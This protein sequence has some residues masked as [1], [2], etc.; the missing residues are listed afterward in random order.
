MKKSIFLFCFLLNISVSA[1]FWSEL[2]G[3]LSN[4]NFDTFSN[5]A[6][7]YD[8]EL[9]NGEVVYI[10]AKDR[11]EQWNG[12]SWSYV[13]SNGIPTTYTAGL[14]LVFCLATDNLGNLY[15]AGR[16][17]NS[18]GNKFV[19]KWDGTA[20][21][22]LGGQNAL[23]AN[24]DI[25]AIYIDAN[26]NVFV[27]GKFKN[28]QG[29]VYVAKYD[30]VSWSSLGG[31]GLTDN[32]LDY[33]NGLAGSANGTIYCAGSFANNSSNQYLAACNQQGWFELGGNNGLAGNYASSNWGGEMNSVVV[34]A[35]NNVYV[36]GNFTNDSGNRFVAKYNGSAWSELGGANALASLG[37]FNGGVSYISD[38]YSVN[39][40]I[41]VTGN[42]TSSGP[43]RFVAR[44]YNNQWTELGADGS[45]G[46]TSWIN[47]IAANNSQI[48]VAGNFGYSLFNGNVTARYVATADYNVVLTSGCMDPAACNFDPDAVISGDC[49]F[50]G[51]ACDD[52]NV[53]TM[54]DVYNDLCECTGMLIIPGCMDPLACNYDVLANMDDGGCL[55]EG[56]PCDDGD[57]NTMNDV[58]SANC[59]CIGTMIIS[60]CT[61]ASACN[62]NVDAN[63]D[64]GSCW[65]VGDVCDD[66]NSNTINDAVNANCE[67]QG[68][69]ISEVE[70]GVIATIKIFPIPANHQ[71]T[72]QW[73]S[74]PAESIQVFDMQGARVT[75]IAPSA[76]QV[77]NTSNWSNG[78][79][80]LLSS[81]GTLRSKIEIR[82]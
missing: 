82:H 71:L 63:T 6:M 5:N 35:Q 42:Y 11:V 81:N 66:G 46:A 79:Y 40:N 20:W 38:V 61:D 78:L 1:Q 72:I 3:Y 19:A 18:V 65:M 59:D 77:I 69:T 29:N 30:G 49:F 7:I 53:T 74:A 64:D 39:D 60:G 27:G 80:L 15:A 55:I 4:Y 10:T 51:S 75:L 54:N 23:H 13:G 52:G 45:L 21:T 36:G 68:E 28:A 67:C 26:N 62:F 22:E 37:V 14:D 56:D 33:I 24:D 8:V 58:L 41:F 9:G 57:I 2:G 44:Y 76:A 48:Y 32:N 70:D 25:K 50:I 17:E 34:D 16:F 12:T 31:T 47:A 43:N 73:K